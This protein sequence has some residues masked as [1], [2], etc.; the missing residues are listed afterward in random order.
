MLEQL[1]SDYTLRT[2]A[3]GSAMLG[4]VS[5]AL[6]SFAVLRRQ[7]LLGDAISHA[8]LPGV[9]IAFL[10]TGSKTPLVLILGAALAGWVATLLILAVTERTRVKYD[11]ALALMLAVFFGFGLV[12]LTYI[13]KQAGAG[14]AGLDTFLFGQA[15]ALV[16]QDVITMAVL[17][18][19]ALSVVA[20]LW[21]EFKLLSF[22][23]E[24]GHTLG[25][26]M[27]TL[28]AAL[29]SLMVVAIVIGL[30]T[31]GVVL[32]SA[33]IIAPA[34]AARQWTDRLGIMVAL[35]ALFGLLAGVSGSVIS[36][37][38]QNLPTGPMIV[39]CVSMLVA[40]SFLLAPNRG[41]VWRAVR[42]WRNARRLRLDT[43][44]LDLYML[45][46]QHEEREHPHS[47]AVL[48]VM[49]EGA[50]RTHRTL[51]ALAERGLAT[52]VE[53]SGWALTPEGAV[54]AREVY[55]SRFPGAE[56]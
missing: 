33:M 9:A 48:N 29:T 38:M 21:K 17:G 12:L 8:S 43:V 18:A 5:G 55:R 41:L 13:Q 19:V 15:A 2:V 40:V 23:S 30:Q 31:V 3:L 50:G 52:H 34:A 42:G 24:F 39:L 32:M 14:Q 4:I 10:L 25:L 51:K 56:L 20:V 36:S 28:D 6:G 16:E 7:S 1:F 53:G 11:S 22:D 35:G 47:E 27:R 26:P 49:H 44:L 54:R 46:G 45:A 37:T